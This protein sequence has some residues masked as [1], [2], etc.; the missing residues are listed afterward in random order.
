MGQAKETRLDLCPSFIER[1]LVDQSNETMPVGPGR[2][3]AALKPLI[4]KMRR[5]EATLNGFLSIQLEQ[6]AVLF[7]VGFGN[8]LTT[9]L[10]KSHNKGWKIEDSMSE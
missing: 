4:Y 1:C 2:V 3:S 7:E 8:I 6:A 5:C 10:F 9:S